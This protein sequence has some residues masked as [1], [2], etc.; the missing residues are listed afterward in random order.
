MTPSVENLR[1]IN[2][3]RQSGNGQEL[4]GFPLASLS[5]NVLPNQPSEPE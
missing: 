1:G 5:R 4:K 3:K 2:S